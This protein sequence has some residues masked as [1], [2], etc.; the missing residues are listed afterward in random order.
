MSFR[1]QSWA[2][3][4]WKLVTSIVFCAGLT[5]PYAA[6]A[7]TLRS[8]DVHPAG[9]PTVLAVEH[10]GQLLSEWTGGRLQ[11][12][13]FS[14]GSLGEEGETFNQTISGHLD[15]V[16]ISVSEVAQFVPEIS[17]LALPYIFRSPAHMHQIVDGPI[18]EEILK[19]LEP[20]G[21]VGLAFYDSGARSFYTRGGS[22][23]SPADL[24]NLRIRV[25]NSP[26]ALAAIEA[27]GAIPIGMNYG[28]VKEALAQG[29]IDG[30]ENN[31]PSYN[32]SGHYLVASHYSLDEHFI[33]PELLLMSKRSWDQLSIEDQALVRKAAK[34]SVPFMRMK[35]QENEEASRNKLIQAGVTIVENIDKQPFINA[36]TPVYEKFVDTPALKELVARIQAST[37]TGH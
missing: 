18:G 14:G 5:L 30:A 31:W 3:M 26:V 12:M 11:I 25:Q 7:Q 20:H 36:M 4:C 17:V 6:A 9:Y 32:T 24:T 27:L 35:W 21:M 37:A 1:F 23:K 28:E 22:I 13:V 33:I 15:M 19:T 10:M 29:A 34:E 8:A 2:D 16:R